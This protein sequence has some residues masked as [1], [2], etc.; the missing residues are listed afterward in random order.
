VRTFHESCSTGLPIGFL[1]IF[2]VDPFGANR[3][4][5]SY[6]DYTNTA[7]AVTV[8]YWRGTTRQSLNTP[9]HTAAQRALP[10]KRSRRSQC[11]WVCTVVAW[12]PQQTG[13]RTRI[14]TIC[15]AAPR[16]G[17]HTVLRGLYI[18]RH[19]WPTSA[20]FTAQPFSVKE[21]QPRSEG[22]RRA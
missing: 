11:A 8:S 15:A 16:W 21:K 19:Q 10:P 6:R 5:W 22:R 2:C 14:Y 13:Y 1:L 9:A 20:L 17:A 7:R 18:D 3:S 12:L 4:G